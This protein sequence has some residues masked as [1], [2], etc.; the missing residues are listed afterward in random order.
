MRFIQVTDDRGKTLNWHAPPARIVSLVPSD[1]Y[2]L[3]RLGAGDRLIGR[4]RYCVAPAGE[5]EGIEI[6]GGTKDADVDRI[7][8][9]APDLV[10]ANQ[11]E[12][13]K[14]DIDK[15]TSLGLRVL[16]SFPQRVTAG[17]S[18]LARLARAL[19][20]DRGAEPARSL[21]ANA[22]HAQRT[23]EAAR[24]GRRPV[25]TF[26][27]IWMD[28]LMTVHA[29]TFISDVLALAGAENVFADRE[30][31]YPLAADLGTGAP[32]PAD[33]VAGRDVR[34][35]RVTLD[36]VIARAPD[37]ILLP[38]EPHAFTEADAA[39]FRALDIPAAKKQD[40]IVRCDGKDLMWY[41]ARS[42]EG[43][44]RLRALVDAAR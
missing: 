32:L 27:P 19:G 12:N 4:T 41:G 5:V 22:Y 9:L 30:R 44:D 33:R 23:A 34:Y 11:E 8:A 20:L 39:V 37:L 16:V 24:D 6:V 28:P 14:H 35:P 29:S 36:E 40:G 43:L 25:R 18:H 1:T 2:S 42:F 13:S 7:A 26:V 38:D 17:L 31:R 10:I 3:L 21:V 15:L